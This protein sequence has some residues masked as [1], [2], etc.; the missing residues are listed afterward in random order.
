MEK[1]KKICAVL[2]SDESVFTVTAIGNGQVRRL[3]G[4]DRYDQQYIFERV[5]NFEKRTWR[6]RHKLHYEMEELLASVWED[7]S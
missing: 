7:P 2:W 5:K 1:V 6:K 3:E 4:G